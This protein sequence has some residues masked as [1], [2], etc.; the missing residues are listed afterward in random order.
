M[1]DTVA[2]SHWVEKWLQW[3]SAG[4]PK[5]SKLTN[6]FFLLCRGCSQKA[7]SEMAHWLTSCEKHQCINKSA[8]V[9]GSGLA[10]K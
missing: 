4:D 1:F 3:L 5:Y 9:G 2:L 8:T 6:F 10:D 7:Q